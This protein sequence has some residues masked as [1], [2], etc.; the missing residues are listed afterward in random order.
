MPVRREKDTTK[1]EECENVEKG[2]GSQGKKQFKGQK[3]E[4]IETGK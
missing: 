4:M 1:G 3:R 2:Q